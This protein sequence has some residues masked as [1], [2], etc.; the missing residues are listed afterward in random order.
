LP[1]SVAF[2]IATLE[3]SGGATVNWSACV[4]QDRGCSYEEA[5]NAFLL[6]FDEIANATVTDQQLTTR[7]LQHPH[8]H[9]NL[10]EEIRLEVT[11]K[12]IVQEGT[13]EAV[14]WINDNPDAFV[15]QL[16]QADDS[17]FQQLQ[18]VE[19]ESAFRY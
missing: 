15:K 2:S 17:F 7:L 12:I 19:A 3:W 5:I 18:D 13:T 8:D 1:A 16:L 6:S 14:K 9:R 11:S 10:D 4:L